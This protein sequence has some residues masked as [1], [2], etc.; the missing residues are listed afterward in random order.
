MEKRDVAISENTIAL[1]RYPD[2][3]KKT[4]TPTNPPGRWPEDR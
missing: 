4:S 2:I 1:I 3:T